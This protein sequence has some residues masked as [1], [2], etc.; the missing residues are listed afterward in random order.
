MNWCGRGVLEGVNVK[1][2]TPHVEYRRHFP[3]E[4]QRSWR[5]RG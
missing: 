2:Q 1:C 5:L 4:T 3:C